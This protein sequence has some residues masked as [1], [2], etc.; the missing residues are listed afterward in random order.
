MLYLQMDTNTKHVAMNAVSANTTK[1]SN[2]FHYFYSVS[3]F[4]DRVEQ[5]HHGAA[6]LCEEEY[7]DKPIGLRQK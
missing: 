3:T 2:R 6:K 5:G 1:L 7:N 4:S